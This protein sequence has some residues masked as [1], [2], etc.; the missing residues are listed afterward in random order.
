MTDFTHALDTAALPN[1]DAV[2]QVRQS[3]AT[4]GRAI[5]LRVMDG[6]DLRLLPH[7]GLDIGSAW[8]AG[9]PLAWVSQVGETGPLLELDEMAWAL[10]FGGGLLT[11]CGLRNVETTVTVTAESL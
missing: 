7:R 3:E 2:L 8:F 4:H 10:A 5:D 11:T 9:K 6:I 1:L